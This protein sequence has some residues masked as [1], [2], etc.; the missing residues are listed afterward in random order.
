VF[1]TWMLAGREVW[2]E[3]YKFKEKNTVGEMEQDCVGA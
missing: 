2:S 3:G 1:E